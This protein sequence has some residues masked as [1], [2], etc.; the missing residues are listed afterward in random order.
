MTIE[1]RLTNLENLVYSYIKSNNKAL[2]E[3]GYDIDGTRNSISTNSAELTNLSNGISEDWEDKTNY[4][5]GEYRMLNNVLYK[6]VNDNIGIEPPNDI[7][8]EKTDI[9]T[10]LNNII[11]SIKE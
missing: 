7:Y 9:A 4:K 11:N 3:K 8:W 2:Q 6:C 1:Q 10:E 5:V